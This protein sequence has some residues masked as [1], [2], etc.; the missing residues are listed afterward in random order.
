MSRGSSADSS[1]HA[2][3]LVALL[4][5][6]AVMGISSCGGGGGSGGTTPPLSAVMVNSLLD[7]ASPP[8]G[9]VTLRSALEAAAS[10]QRITF[11][12]TLNGSTINLIFVGE[13]HTVLTGE[14]MGFDEANN[15]SYLVGY[16][17]RDYGKSALFADKD[18]VIDAS[19]LPDGI[20]INWDGAEPARVLA[21]AGDLTLTNVAVT[22]GNSVFDVAADIGQHPDD[23]QTS[24]LARGAGI[25]VWGVA[26]LTDCAIYDNHAV[27]DDDRGRREPGR[28]STAERCRTSPPAACSRPT[29]RA[30]GSATGRRALAR[31]RPTASRCLTIEPGIPRTATIV[32]AFRHRGPIA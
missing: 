27:G 16:F 12:P 28:W 18:V 30:T 24:T 23:N 26:T 4:S 17:D 6:L 11:D 25:A 29:G 1:V 21:V 13:D 32:P 7:D 10:G 5:V 2:L 9:T 22:G 15:I 31:S 14:V 19:D 20:T 3:L 8:A